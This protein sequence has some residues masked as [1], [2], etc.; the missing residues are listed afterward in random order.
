MKKVVCLFASVILVV[1][2]NGYAGVV[3]A[4]SQ[5][6]DA[7]PQSGD[8][9]GGTGGNGQIVSVGS[10][11]F[12]MKRNDDGRNQIIHLTG[13]PTIKTSNGV[14][15]LSDLEAGDR[16][17]LVGGPNGDGSFTADTVF[18]CA[19]IQEHVT[20]QIVQSAQK[21]RTVNG[22]NVR[23][24]SVYI[25]LSSILLAGLIW[26]GIVAFL[27]RKKKKRFVYVLFFTIFYIYIVKV[28]DYTLFQYQSLI[29]LKH[30]TSGLMLNGQS[31]EKSLN[32]IPLITL[33]QEDVKTSL[34]NILLMIPFGFGLPFIT[35]VRMKKVVIFGGLVSIT[36]E[37]LQLLT[38]LMAKITFRIADVNDVIFNTCGVVIGYMLFIGF[39]RMYRHLFHS[40]KISES[41]IMRYIGE[42]PQIDTNEH[43]TL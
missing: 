19:T 42:R 12:T 15:S 29:L 39:L 20:D 30:F 25:N 18:V 21:Q 26:V 36:I 16:V 41:P 1:A 27:W 14:A 32:L 22:T 24:W 7:I 40:W 3:M 37:L 2:F 17:T 23:S 5:S 9:C 28:L 34:L 11:S 10:N 43:N 8:L 6:S 35:N 4:V 31:A 13:Q 38:G 33:T